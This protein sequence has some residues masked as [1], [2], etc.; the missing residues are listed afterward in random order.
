M[1]DLALKRRLARL[2]LW[3]E[4][5]WLAAWPVLAV[6]GLFLVFA[7]SGLPALLPGWTHLLVL[8]GFAAGLVLALRV[9]WRGLR[10]PGAA[11][12]DRRLEAES[13][14]RHRP[15]AALED[16]AAGGDPGLW[17][18]H[19]ERMRARIGRLRVGW[20]RPGLAARDQRALR[21]GLG[22]AVL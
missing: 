19:Q 21:A 22:V 10:R 6:L 17:A 18:A 16:R 12:A 7:W 13:G 14:L 8:L 20:P 4:G 15:L 11:Q 2:A 5:A 1:R 9:G 3:W